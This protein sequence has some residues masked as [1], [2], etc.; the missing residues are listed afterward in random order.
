MKRL[1]NPLL[2]AKQV[3]KKNKSLT[4]KKKIIAV[5]LILLAV[6]FFS[7][8]IKGSKNSQYIT[9]KAER[10]SVTETVSETGTITTNGKTFS[11]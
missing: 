9:T 5:V 7:N 6:Y 10:G 1:V 11:N 3:F 2:L 8:F 4:L